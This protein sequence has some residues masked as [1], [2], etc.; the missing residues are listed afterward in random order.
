MVKISFILFLSLF[1]N[2]HSNGQSWDRFEYDKGQFSILSPDSLEYVVQE[3]QTDLGK[4][5]YHTYFYQL[6]Q[7]EG[8]IILMVSFVDYP[9]GS[10]H[11][12]STEILKN[13][14]DQTATSA[15]LSINGEIAYQ[16]Q[17]QYHGYPQN[18]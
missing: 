15:A 18:Y 2:I 1:L 8:D 10:I 16:S 3:F 9:I 12:D 14:F 17:D 4:Q 13:F 6:T 5:M 11:S 7:E